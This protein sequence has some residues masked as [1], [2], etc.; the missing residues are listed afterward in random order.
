MGTCKLVLPTAAEHSGGHVIPGTACRLHSHGT[1]T[2]IVYTTIVC[3]PFSVHNT[4]IITF[5]L[6]QAPDLLSH[7]V[8]R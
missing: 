2:T 7:L 1:F 8:E 3:L 6:I 4:L 5:A